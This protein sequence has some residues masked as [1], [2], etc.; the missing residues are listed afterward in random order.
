MNGHKNF[1]RIA[2]AEAKTALRDGEFPVGCV[3]VRD[4]QVLAYGR[5]KNS[6]GERANEI[7]HAEVVALRTLLHSAPRTDC[8]KITVYSTM[9]PCLMCFTTM[10]LSGIRRFVWA[11]EDVMG[12][13]TNLP[14]SQLN[15]LYAGMQ[16]EIVPRVL[17]NE[18]LLLFQKFFQDYSYWQGSRLA[19]Y[20]LAQSV[21]QDS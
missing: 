4:N 19:E 17:R 12:G 6:S 7:D 2:L 18:S 21:E 3:F 1:M 8:S 5:R 20:T 15:E 14:L 9:E 13:G 11:Y 10:L 16:V